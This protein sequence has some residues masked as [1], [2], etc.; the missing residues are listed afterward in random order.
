MRVALAAIVGVGVALAAIRPQPLH[1]PPEGRQL[2][3][4]RSPCLQERHRLGEA[5]HADGPPSATPPVF[6]HARAARAAR[7]AP[8]APGAVHSAHER[9][10]RMEGHQEQELLGLLGGSFGR[11]LLPHL[12]PFE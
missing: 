10:V 2:L 8:R 6:A 3:A 1:S 11:L 5:Q 4:R 9:L 7:A 12:A